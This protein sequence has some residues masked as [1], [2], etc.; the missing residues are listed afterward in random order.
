MW[1][2]HRHY[3]FQKVKLFQLSNS[4]FPAFFRLNIDTQI[5]VFFPAPGFYPADAIYTAISIPHFLFF[6]G[7]VVGSILLAPAVAPWET[8]LGGV[9]GG[10]GNNPAVRL[11]EYERA[12]GI[13]RD[14]HQYYLDLRSAN[15]GAGDTWKS[16]YNATEYYSLPD[17]STQSLEKLTEQLWSSDD[18]FGKYYKA[19]GVLYDPDEKWD[20]ET[21]TVHLCAISQLLYEE[22]D[23]CYR[24]HETSTAPTHASSLLGIGTLALLALS[25]IF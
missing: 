17:F 3:P 10:A 11:V 1:H 23:E 4:L 22:Y 21:R 25:S 16:L 20:E 8:T 9:M 13:V 24:G 7:A 5:L 15:S 19:N 14:V 6:S 12:T 18:L 2:E